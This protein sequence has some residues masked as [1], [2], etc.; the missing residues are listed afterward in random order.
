M[1]IMVSRC[2]L[3]VVSIIS[4]S[5]VSH[6]ALA[7]DQLPLP[8]VAPASIQAQ[9]E[10]FANASSVS[11]DTPKPSASACGQYLKQVPSGEKIRAIK[12]YR[13][14]RSQEALQQLAVW[15][16]QEASY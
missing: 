9:I 7:L 2:L 1:G 6:Q 10:E 15:R 16:W 5:F 3:A 8:H 4:A 13:E 12:A 14:C 11:A